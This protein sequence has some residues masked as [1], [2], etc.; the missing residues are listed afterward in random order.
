MR[1]VIAG[2]GRHGA[3]LARELN[4]LGHTAAVIDMD[5]ASFAR[6]G[7]TFRG[8][9]FE[10]DA[11]DRETLLRAGI[12][13]ADG[14]AA[15]T[16]S[17]EVNVVIAR[18]ADQFFRVPVVVARL[19][20][21]A[22]ADTYRRLGLRTVA[23]VTWATQRAIELLTHSYLDTVVTL[24]NGQVDIVEVEIPPQVAGRTVSELSLPGELLLTA[25]T[26]SGKTFLPAPSTILQSGDRVAVAV[27]SGSADRLRSLFNLA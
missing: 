1:V 15:A 8:E 2:C 11:M 23:P 18:L 22:K 16:N 19:Y 9:T 17:D 25:V 6:L 27:Q 7:P 20:D 5:P 26:R 24:G 12:E 3:G 21:N 10:G 13:R 14:L 4:Q